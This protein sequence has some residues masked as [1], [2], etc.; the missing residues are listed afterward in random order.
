M[1][2]H[3]I[4]FPSEQQQFMVNGCFDQQNISDYDHA[5][6]EFMLFNGVFGDEG[7]NFDIDEITPS[8]SHNSFAINDAP[9]GN[10]GGLEE[11]QGDYDSSGTTRVMAE[12][13]RP[14][15]D[16]SRTLVSERRRRGQMKERLYE[17]RSIV[18]N[19]TKMDK[20]SIIAD[21][22]VYVQDLQRQSKKLKED[23]VVLESSMKEELM[24]QAPFKNNTRIETS[25]HNVMRGK[26]L[27][28]VADEVADR[29]FFV[30]VECNKGNGLAMC[31]YN[32]MESLAW[33]RLQSSNFS[34][35]TERCKLTMN[36]NVRESR[37]DMNASSVKL[38][39][40]GALLKQ[41]FEFELMA[42]T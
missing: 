21:A 10:E 17:L 23:I 12:T 20:A 7:I 1:E 41:G 40:M 35:S 36:L 24:F 42:I 15:R 4:F 31:L 28:L 5:L 32:A 11:N 33:F 39:I 25:E 13:T 14:K 18:P 19:I 30:V 6:A 22:V 2:Q 16:R 27:K 26:I 37:E 34:M 29:S 3:S 38:W 8:T 9:G